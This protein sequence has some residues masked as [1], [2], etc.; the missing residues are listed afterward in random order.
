MLRDERVYCCDKDFL[1]MELAVLVK[2]E[3]EIDMFVTMEF[4]IPSP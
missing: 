2:V 3:K 4:K 1:N